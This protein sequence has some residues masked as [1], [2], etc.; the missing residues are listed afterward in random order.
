MQSSRPVVRLLGYAGLLPFV[1]PVIMVYLGTPF[2]AQARGVAEVYA[3]GIISFLCG[4]WWGLSLRDDSPKVFWLS[5][6]IFLLAFFIFL[7][8]TAW[9][10]LAAAIILTSL[11]FAEQG[12]TL[13]DPFPEHYRKLRIHLTAVASAAMLLLQFSPVSG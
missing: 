11:L 2:A 5:N 7:F 6:L 1:V 13:F 10:P 3:F 8:A 9:W 4:S 12:N